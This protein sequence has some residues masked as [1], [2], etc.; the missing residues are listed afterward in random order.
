MAFELCT[1]LTLE[2]STKR[3]KSLRIV[4]L[5]ASLHV[6]QTQALREPDTG[7][8]FGCPWGQFKKARRRALKA[9]TAAQ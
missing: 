3:L 6:I 4:V 7:L 2:E 8:H 9:R 1:N 5:L